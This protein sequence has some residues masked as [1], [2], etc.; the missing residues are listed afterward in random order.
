M[1]IGPNQLDNKLILARHGRISDRPFRELCKQFVSLAG[2]KWWPNRLYV[3][4][5]NAVKANHS[6]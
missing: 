6:G 5:K 1:K 3:T 4:I 2:L